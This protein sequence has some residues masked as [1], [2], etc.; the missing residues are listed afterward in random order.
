[1]KDE[2]KGR[3]AR[4]VTGALVELKKLEVNDLEDGS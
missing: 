2:A 1:M 4:F 3:L